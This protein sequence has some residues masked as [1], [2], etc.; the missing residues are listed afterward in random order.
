MAFDASYITGEGKGLYFSALVM[1]FKDQRVAFAALAGLG[2]VFYALASMGQGTMWRFPLAAY[3]ILVIL[4]GIAFM[5]QGGLKMSIIGYALTTVLVILQFDTTI[6]AAMENTAVGFFKSFSLA[7]TTASTMLLVY[8]MDETGALKVMADVI[9]RQ[10][11]GDEMQALY[12]GLGFGSFLT[13]LGVTTPT[14]FPPLLLS[15][16]F[17]PLQSVAVAVLGYDP[18]TSFAILGLP[19][20][21]PAQTYGFS[22]IDF[23]YK[24]SLF[25][26]I[27]STAFSLSILWLLGGMKSIRKGFVPAVL[28]GLTISLA[29]L[30][31]SYIDYS[32]AYEIIPVRI[33]G[34]IAGAM[35]MGMLHIYERIKGVKKEKG[36]PIGRHEL[37]CFSPLI[38]LLALAA[39]ISIPQI[40]SFL[41]ALP[42]DLEVI[43][44][45]SQKVDLDLLS[46]TYTWIF[47][48]TGLSFF[49]LKP[50]KDEISRTKTTWL[51]RMP[52]NV[53]ISVL[54][55]CLAWVMAGSSINKVL[56]DTLTLIF[57]VAYIYAASTLGYV[58]AIAAGSETTSTI[59]F[60]KI[61]K[62]AATNLNLGDKGF[63]SLIASH[64]VAGGVASAVTPSKIASSVNTIDAGKEVEST[65]LRKNL[66]ISLLIL[67]LV[68]LFAG[69]L[70]T[71]QV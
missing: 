48:A 63:M 46:Q 70:I 30:L 68:A 53:V 14:L 5:R 44:I 10:V 39:T 43:H 6:Q 33:M 65:I 45:G 23:A 42:G 9:K 18:T 57:G 34:V 36:P 40:G 27:V 69:L 54:F 25:L 71:M 31:F 50:K 64:G 20:T 32:L 61:Q 37:K 16:G 29:C 52:V 51:K 15:M 56:G 17:T 66:L 62:A 26:P 47:I 58:G 35:T 60:Y 49:T 11:Q 59:L 2:V 38:I 13:C 41:S 28:S 22:Q 21:L 3:P 7:L 19:I 8:L 12:I 67:V 1:D 4:I 55:F 24:I